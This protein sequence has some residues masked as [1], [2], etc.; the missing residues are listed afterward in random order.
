MNKDFDFLDIITV[1]SFA[2]GL[3]AYEL[4]KENLEENRQQTNDTQKILK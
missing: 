1:I 3:Q 2:I 4:A